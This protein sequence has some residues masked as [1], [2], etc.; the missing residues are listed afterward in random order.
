MDVQSEY[1]FN[2]RCRR[3]SGLSCAPYYL[4]YE[5]AETGMIRTP[6]SVQQDSHRLIL[7]VKVSSLLWQD[8]QHYDHKY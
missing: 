3:G 6:S 8:W 2:M 4:R 7:D 1:N 5:L